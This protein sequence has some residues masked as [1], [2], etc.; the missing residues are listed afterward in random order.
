VDSPRLLIHLASRLAPITF[1]T[2]VMDSEL[3]IVP[4]VLTH[5]L[6]NLAKTFRAL[7]TEPERWTIPHY[8]RGVRSILSPL[9]PAFDLQRQRNYHK[10]GMFPRSSRL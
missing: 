1:D 2:D 7:P 6:A 4:S 9:P 10:M 5:V 3:G 8:I